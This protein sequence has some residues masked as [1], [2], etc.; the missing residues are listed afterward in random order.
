MIQGPLMVADPLVVGIEQNKYKPGDGLWGANSETGHAGRFVCLRQAIE[1]I[2]Q[3][4]DG[5]RLF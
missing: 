3:G 2:R 5:G 1:K 4:G